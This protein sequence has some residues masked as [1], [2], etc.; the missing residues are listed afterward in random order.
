MGLGKNALHII[1]QGTQADITHV[2]GRTTICRASIERVDCKRPDYLI[3]SQSVT[4]LLTL[5]LELRHRL[6]PGSRK[7]RFPFKG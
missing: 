2:D 4:H 7:A 6:E 5:P 3:V 1:R